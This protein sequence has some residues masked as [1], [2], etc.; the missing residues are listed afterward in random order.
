VTA[1]KMPRDHNWT[2]RARRNPPADAIETPDASLLNTGLF[3]DGLRAVD[4]DIDDSTV[5]ATCI[6]VARQILGPPAL[7]RTRP[8]SNRIACLYR[9]A[10]GQPRKVSVKGSD[11]ARVEVLGYGNQLHCF[12]LHPSGVEPVWHPAPPGILRVDELSAV[13]E[14]QVDEFLTTIAPL[15][16]APPFKRGS[17]AGPIR[18]RQ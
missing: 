13:T 18:S 12:G 2:G 7:T 3:L 8:G 10:E 17:R 9:A 15:I 16:G 4:F 5:E 1:D 11:G 6:A 14:A